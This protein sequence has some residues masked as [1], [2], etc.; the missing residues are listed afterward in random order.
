MAKT[1]LILGVMSGSSLDG[2]DMALCRFSAD[3]DQLDYEVRATGQATYD[4]EWL[5]RLRQVHRVDLSTYFTWNYDYGVW[6]GKKIADFAATSKAAPDLVSVHGHSVIHNPAAHFSVQLGH[7]AAISAACSF[8]V[9]CDVRSADMALGGQG[10]PL[11]HLADLYLYPGYAAYLNL[12]GI[13][14]I[15]LPSAGKAWDLCGAN[16]LLN[17]MA[18]LLGKN[19]DDRGTLAAT[20]QVVPGLLDRLNADHYLH[21][22]P[23]KSLDN[24]YVTDHFTR[25]LLEDRHP[26][27][28]RLATATEHIAQAVVGA[29]NHYTISAGKILITGGGAYNDF[30]IER[31]RQRSEEARLGV[32]WIVPEAQILEY[33]EAVL[34]A[35]MGY[36]RLEHQA[37][38]LPTYTGAS[39]PSLNG[40]LYQTFPAS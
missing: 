23:P 21:E 2:L 10:A 14:N 34:M 31:F 18:R 8:P 3:G 17:A 24:Q 4:D 37:N 16:Q 1:R 13:A 22:D 33:K 15:T 7:G 30:L 32:E 9:M 29:L 40:A 20:G 27:E 25:L 6:L 26:V 36:L 39:G 38:C 12:G 35:L 28:D 19:F 11:A 5:E